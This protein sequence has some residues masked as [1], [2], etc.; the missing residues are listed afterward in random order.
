MALWSRCCQCVKASDVGGLLLIIPFEVEILLSGLLIAELGFGKSVFEALS[1]TSGESG[2]IQS[3][4]LGV[5]LEKVES[6]VGGDSSSGVEDLLDRGRGGGDGVLD[7]LVD[8]DDVG[9]I[10]WDNQR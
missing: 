8:V 1:E 5:S 3:R 4:V 10:V 9:F 7:L 6:G 2:D